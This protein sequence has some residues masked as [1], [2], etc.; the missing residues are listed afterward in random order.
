M[1]SGRTRRR[2]FLPMDGGRNGLIR[3]PPRRE[4]GRS[5]LYSS[6]KSL[7]SISLKNGTD[8]AFD[9]RPGFEGEKSSQEIFPPQS[10]PDLPFSLR[11]GRLLEHPSSARKSGHTPGGALRKSAVDRLLRR[12]S[13]GMVLQ[14]T[15]ADA[16]VPC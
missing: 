13:M 8:E 10:R 4:K 2:R 7:G 15:G 14:T 16:A 6:T 3:S 5:G 11:G 9:A 12:G 1:V